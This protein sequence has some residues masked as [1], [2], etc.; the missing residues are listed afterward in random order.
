MKEPESKMAVLAF[1]DG[2]H[3]AIPPAGNSMIRLIAYVLDFAEKRYIGRS[4]GLPNQ[5]FETHYTNLL[6]ENLQLQVSVMDI[7]LR[8]QFWEDWYQ[9]ADFDQSSSTDRHFVVDAVTGEIHFGNNEKGMIPAFSEEVDNIR[10]ITCQIGG[11]TRGNV[12]KHLIQQLIALS[13][14]FQGVKATNMNVAAGGKERETIEDAKRRVQKQL[15]HPYRAITNEDYEQIAKSTPGLRVARVKAIPLFKL[16]L[17]DYPIQKA[18]AQITVVAVP[19]SESKKPMPSKG[20]LNTVRYQLDRHRL[21]T[22]EIHVIAPEYI[23]ITVH[24][25]VVVEAH[26]QNEADRIIKILNEFIQPL[27]HYDQHSNHKAG[28]EFGRS[29]YKGDIYGEINRIQGIEYVQDLWLS[30]EGNGIRKEANGDI[31]IPPHA[32]VYSGDHQIEIRSPLDI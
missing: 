12:K 24:A 11:G 21:I 29:V 1:G 9:V 17:K 30:A 6:K 22:T 31:H 27:D 28:W 23:K 25:V 18:A 5:Q 13:S 15:H 20:F 3:G 16:G 14:D 19:Y 10:W 2:V 7:A 8:H 32:L 26:L 4:N